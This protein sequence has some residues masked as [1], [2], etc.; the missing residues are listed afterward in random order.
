MREELSKFKNKEVA[1]K[2]RVISLQLCNG[3]IKVL[4]REVVANGIEVGHI[5]LFLPCRYKEVFECLINKK[6]KFKGKVYSYTKNVRIDGELTG[7]RKE[8]YSINCKT[9]VNPISS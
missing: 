2:G 4:L 1:V 6:V 5:W 3:K 7:I 8:D 9:K